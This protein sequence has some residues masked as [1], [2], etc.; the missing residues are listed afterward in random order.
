MDLSELYRLQ[1]ELDATIAKNVKEGYNVH[2]HYAVD[3]IRYAFHTEM[4]EL[5]NEVGF[6]KF[7]KNSHTIDRGKTLEELVDCIHFLLKLGLMKGYERTVKKVE[8]YYFWE[9]TIIDEFFYLIQDNV[10]DSVYHYDIAFACILAI[11]RKL[12][13]TE[14]DVIHA[15]KLKNRKNFERQANNY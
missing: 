7:W 4:A 11:A 12:D 3:H 1:H 6:F 9:D 5:A 14:S 13:Y 8:P 15:Y 2:S 10:L